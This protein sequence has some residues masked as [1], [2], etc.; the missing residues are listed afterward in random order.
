METIKKYLYYVYK[1]FLFSRGKAKIYHT[2]KA[3]SRFSIAREL[4]QWLFKEGY[5]NLNYYAFGLNIAGTKQTDYIGR[6]TFL[7]LKNSAER[8]LKK[9]HK[10]EGINFEAITKDKFY[11]A[12]LLYANGIPHVKTLA[13]ISNNQ[14]S[15]ADGRFSKFEDLLSLP[16]TFFIKNTTLEAGDGVKVCLVVDNGIKMNGKYKKLSEVKEELSIGKWIVQMG[17]K[18]GKSIARINNSALNTTRIVTILNGDKP[19][20]LTGFQSFA[21]NNEPTDSWSKG[22]VYVGIDIASNRLKKYAY[23][24][25]HLKGGALVE[26]HPDSRIVFENYEIPQ[27]QDAVD[28]CLKAHRLLYFNFVIGWDVAI[29]ENGPV[30]LEANEKPGMNAVQCL[31]GG[32]SERIYEYYKT[33]K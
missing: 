18:S 26:S 31:D 33:I 10:N 7:K 24:H 9:Y 4:F 30:I 1:I 13:W 17:M 11:F 14:I 8:K 3:K 32:L 6:R 2:G 22:S 20:Y 25:P 21:T 28:L 5:F 27:L 16:G 23:Y 19:E 15:S 29:T 12:S